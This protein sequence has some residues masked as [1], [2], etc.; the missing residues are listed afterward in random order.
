MKRAVTANA[1]DNEFQVFMN[2][3]SQA[4]VI[5]TCS[6]IHNDVQ[7]SWGWETVWDRI[8]QTIGGPT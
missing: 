2:V 1:A 6:I 4:L 7:L 8:S 5:S 3:Q